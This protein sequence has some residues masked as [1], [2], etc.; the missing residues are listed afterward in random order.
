MTE[1]FLT[2][3]GNAAPV[4]P[5]TGWSNPAPLQ[6]K[7]TRVQAGVQGFSGEGPEVDPEEPTEFS[8]LLLSVQLLFLPF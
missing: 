1:K 3:K 8:L 2:L 5:G 4:F 7:L 6:V